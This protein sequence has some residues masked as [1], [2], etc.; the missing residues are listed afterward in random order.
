MSNFDDPEGR[1]MGESWVATFLMWMALWATLALI[2]YLVLH[3]VRS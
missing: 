2:G 1:N 3:E